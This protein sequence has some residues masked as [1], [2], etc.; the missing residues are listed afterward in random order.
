VLSPDNKVVLKTVALGTRVGNRWVVS[1]GIEP[2]DRVLV[3]SPQVRDGTVVNPT[4]QAPIAEESPK[5]K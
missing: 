4:L 2:N 1:R 3:D 5:G